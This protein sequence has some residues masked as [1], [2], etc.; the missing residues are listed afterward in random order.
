MSNATYSPSH[1]QPDAP[2]RNIKSTLRT[3]PELCKNAS[4]AGLFG[5]NGNSHTIST[6][7]DICTYRHS[8]Q[9]RDTSRVKEIKSKWE[10]SECRVPFWARVPQI[11][12]PWFTRYMHNSIY[13]SMKIMVS[14]ESMWLKMG[15]SWIILAGFPYQILT[16]SV[17]WI[18]CIYERSFLLYITRIF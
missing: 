13:G 11:C 4:L 12:Q 14:Y 17:K 8:S 16:N 3:A 1:R 18:R 7:S 15:I 5:S 9:Y 2:V 10:S 6:Q